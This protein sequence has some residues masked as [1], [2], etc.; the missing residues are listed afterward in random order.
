MKYSDYNTIEDFQKLIDENHISTKNEFRKSYK[1]LYDRYIRLF[2]R[3]ERLLVFSGK[4]DHHMFFDSYSTVEDFQKFIDD[5]NILKPIQM[6]KQFPKIYDRLCRILSKEDKTKLIYKNRINSY[7]DILTLDDLQNYVIS[8]EIHSKKEL[9]KKF[10]GLY[11]KFQKQ[12]DNINFIANNK[13]IGENFLEKIFKDNNI[14]FET[15]KTYKNLKNILPLRYDF[16]LSEYNILI[17]HH[18]EEHFGKGRY[19]SEELILN[20]KKKYH[21]AVENKIPILY[22][23]IYKSEYKSCGYFTEVITDVNVLLNKINEIRMTS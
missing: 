15:Q 19:Y 21:Y 4:E 2:S 17:E 9:H 16:Y 1:A 6:R 11:T 13:S 7:K 14:K 18:G 12:L 8:N 3:N 5:N 22:F 10:S 23:T 20:D